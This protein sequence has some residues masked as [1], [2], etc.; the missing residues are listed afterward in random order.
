[1]G[2]G[3]TSL[4]AINMVAAATNWNIYSFYSFISQQSCDC[5]VTD[6]KLIFPDI[7]LAEKPVHD[8]TRQQKDVGMTVLIQTNLKRF[9][10]S[11]NLKYFI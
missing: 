2:Q 3:S 10:L 7:D 1:M 8:V 9:L 6:L 4:E 11:I 5:D